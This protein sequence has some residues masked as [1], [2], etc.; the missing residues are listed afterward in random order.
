MLR[1]S[2]LIDKREYQPQNLIP[3]IPSIYMQQ[4]FLGIVNS[5]NISE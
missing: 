3:F 5:N 1:I 2:D 4:Y